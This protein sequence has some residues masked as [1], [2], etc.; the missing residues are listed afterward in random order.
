MECKQDKFEKPEIDRI[1]ANLIQLANDPRVSENQPHRGK[2][3][4]LSASD[5]EIEMI[6]GLREQALVENGLITLNFRS[7][8]AN[9]LKPCDI[10][11]WGGSREWS[12]SV[13]VQASSPPWDARPRPDI[14]KKVRD[15]LKLLK[16]LGLSTGELLKLI[17]DIEF[18]E[19]GKDTSINPKD[20]DAKAATFNV[21]GDLYSIIPWN[22]GLVIVFDGNIHI[23]LLSED[24]KSLLG[25]GFIKDCSLSSASKTVIHELIHVLIAATDCC[26]DDD[27][28]ML[29][30][31]LENAVAA[32]IRWRCLSKKHGENSTQAKKARTWLDFWIGEVK[33]I[34]G[35]KCLEK[36]GIK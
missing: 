5:R 20:E 18:H 23:V 3:Y 26:K 21:E 36:I 19:S 2:T 28:D 6:D 27:D 8:T 9:E 25:G 35:S 29:V 4:G 7:G 16:L 15:L 24:V 30:T 33:S 32:F 17:K 31:N 1:Y 11:F 10:G 22:G 12:G 13:T 34:G 14:S